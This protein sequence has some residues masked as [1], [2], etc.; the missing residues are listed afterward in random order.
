MTEMKETSKAASVAHKMRAGVAGAE[1]VACKA[2]AEI[3]FE[4]GGKKILT[5]ASKDMLRSSVVEG[6]EKVL[7]TV[8]PELGRKAAGVI[9]KGGAKTL[10]KTAGETAVCESG[11]AVA[12]ES[13]KAASRTI[14]RSAGRAAGLGAIIDGGFGLAEGVYRY[15][16]GEMDAGEACIHA[17]KEAG[18]GAAASVAGVALAAGVVALTG[19]LA[20]PLVFSIGAGTSIAA[21]IGLDRL[22]S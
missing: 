2:A 20:V 18:K 15:S 4:T 22:F 16:K 13:A 11:K 10:A 6:T 7:S 17:G 1:S 3:L 14:L 19:G 21:K 8:A 9:G 12:R 5:E